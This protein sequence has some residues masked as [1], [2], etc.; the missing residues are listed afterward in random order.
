MTR[1][2]ILDVGAVYDGPARVIVAG[3]LSVR[4]L[5][6]RLTIVS[7][8]FLLGPMKVLFPRWRFAGGQLI[9]GVK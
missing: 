3:L 8:L 9:G 4:L 1:G 5:R 2:W 6:S 7:F